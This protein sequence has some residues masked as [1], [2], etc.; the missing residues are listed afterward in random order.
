ME[1]QKLQRE[2]DAL[3]ARLTH[4]ERKEQ[5]I[6]GFKYEQGAKVSKLR[7]SIPHILYRSFVNEETKAA[8]ELENIKQE[9]EELKQILDHYQVLMNMIQNEKSTVY[10]RL[11]Q[12]KY[13]LQEAKSRVKHWEREYD[14]AK[15]RVEVMT[16]TSNLDAPARLRKCASYLGDEKMK[17]AEALIANK[18]GDE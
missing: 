17:E 13:K 4:L 18:E 14:I 5:E 9:M 3:I 2:N 6:G 7:S 12:I 8:I 11:E 16:E 10:T 1:L 15:K